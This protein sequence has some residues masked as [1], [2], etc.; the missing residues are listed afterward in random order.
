[1]IEFESGTRNYAKAFISEEAGEVNIASKII[2][3][4]WA[5]VKRP[6]N[7]EINNK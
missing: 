6:E 1:M 3:N 2:E 4:G 5:R 7:P